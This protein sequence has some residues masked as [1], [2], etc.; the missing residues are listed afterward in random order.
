[1][2]FSAFLAFRYFISKSQQNIINI[3]TLISLGVVMVSTASLLVVLSAFSGLKDFGLSFSNA[4]DPDFKIIAAQGKTL[5]LDSL[6]IKNI[7]ALPEISAVTPILEDKVFLSYQGKNQVAFLKGVGADYS[8]LNEIDSLI[9]SGAWIR[10]QQNEVVIGG[11]IARNLSL[12]VYDFSDFLTL[13]S[14]KRK[15]GNKI[16]GQDFINQKALVSGIFLANADLDQK[17]LFSS[18]DFARN[19]FQRDPNEYSSLEV[20]TSENL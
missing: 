11:G 12:G 19:Q 6:Q 4:I 10:D 9:I 13:S 7:L 18:L 2:R 17:Y 1:V 3:I 16:I 20:Y 14:P 15:Q 8:Q 5:S